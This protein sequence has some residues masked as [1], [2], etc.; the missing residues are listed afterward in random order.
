MDDGYMTS[1][2]FVPMLPRKLVWMT[3]EL[4]SMPLSHDLLKLGERD[5]IVLR[6]SSIYPRVRI[7]L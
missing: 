1:R 4:S 2:G 3:P 7:E 5:A 6:H